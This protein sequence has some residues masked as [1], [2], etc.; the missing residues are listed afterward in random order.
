MSNLQA[1]LAAIP[2][3][4]LKGIRRGIEKESLRATAEGGLA[5]TPHPQ[6]LG[7]ALT[8]PH[9]TTDYSE[10]QLELITGVH[11]TPETCLEE[12]MQVH[13]FTYRALGEEMLWVSS[14]PCNLPAD[15]TIPIG[16]YGSSNVGRAK[17]VYRMGLAH[18]YG[19]RMQ[20]IS[21]IH[22]NWSLPDVSSEAYFGLIRNFRRHAFL[23][24]YLFGASPAVCSSF[25]AGRQHELQSLANGTLYMPHGTSLRMGRLGYQS[26]AQASL[27]VSY[28][29]LDGYAASLQE[30]LTRPYPAYEAVGVMNPGGEYNQLATS[31]LQIEN[32]FYGTIRPKRVIRQ[33]ERPLHALR[34]RGVEY[35][36]VRLLDLNP[37]VP[38][39]I[40]V[41]NVRFLDI[42]LMH[43]LLSDSP[44][45]TPQEIAALGRNQ[46]K[47]AAFGRQ[48]GLM[49]ERG[50]G[51]MGL[52]DW[53]D[54]LLQSFAPIAA[55][56]DETHGASDYGDA[57]RAAQALLHEPDL[58]PSAR[59]LAVMQKEFD[60]SFQAF[61]RAQ[62]RQT[63]A[64]LLALPFGAGMQSRFAALSEQSV[65]DQ[66]AIEAADTMPF[67]IYRQQYI[68][69]ER[70]GLSRAAIAPALAA[71]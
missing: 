44:P 17:S 6:A 24:L 50:Q 29:G 57:L 37:F 63:K 61:T 58:L 47:T 14:M 30:A 51:E 12:L 10:A 39:G 35:V 70:L 41:Q 23:L 38:I 34:E 49:L 69:P 60:N 48:P 7:S 26:E 71:V 2:P 33:G 52:T 27:A 40:T 36:E 1:R 59:V 15:E 65:A 32:E 66:K 42:F 4:R 21:G 68:S 67:E 55:A 43:C 64:K 13:Q 9:I 11:A 53:G 54:E 22:Y 45:D 18:R 5:L 8:H 16:H 46:H 19:R 20:T 62:S 31:L 28:N 3:Q 25:V 56:L